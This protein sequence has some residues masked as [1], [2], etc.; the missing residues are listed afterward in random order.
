M[1]Q[2]LYLHVLFTLISR[3]KALQTETL[4][5]QSAFAR[6]SVFNITIAIVP[7]MYGPSSYQ[8]PWG[9]A[10]CNQ[11]PSVLHTSSLSVSLINRPSRLT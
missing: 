10:T 7:S 3:L 1:R 4:A 6:Y 9:K 11:T 2:E 5:A 8:L